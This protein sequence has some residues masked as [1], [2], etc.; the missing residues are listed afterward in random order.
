MSPHHGTKGEK[1]HAPKPAKAYRKSYYK[2]EKNLTCTSKVSASF[3][4]LGSHDSF[5]LHVSRFL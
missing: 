1:T 4:L 2:T 5:I 3:M